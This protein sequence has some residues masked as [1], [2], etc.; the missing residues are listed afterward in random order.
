MEASSNT[1]DNSSNTEDSRAR[2]T[3]M[4]LDRDASLLLLGSGQTAFVIGLRT[5]TLPHIVYAA[6]SV[7]PGFLVKSVKKLGA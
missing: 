5:F 1:E 4:D 6:R 3:H 2:R 7:A